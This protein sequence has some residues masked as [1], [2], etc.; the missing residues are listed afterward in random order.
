MMK[1]AAWLFCLC[2]ILAVEV[3]TARALEIEATTVEQ[4]SPATA[5]TKKQSANIGPR[6]PEPKTHGVGMD[7]ILTK[8]LA[9]CSSVLL[10]PSEHYLQSG[11]TGTSAGISLDPSKL[12]GIVG[13]KVQ[14]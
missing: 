10:P 4:D 3:G 5:A 11:Q 6:E 2:S 14:F 8:N 13:F 1:Y 7:V 9:I 12:S